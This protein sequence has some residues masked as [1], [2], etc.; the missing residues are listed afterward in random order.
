[1]ARHKLA[2]LTGLVYLLVVLAG[3]FTLLYV[4]GK[5]YVRGDASATAANILAFQPLFQ[6]KIIVSIVSEF[7]FVATV[8][9]LYQLLKDVSRPLATAMVVIILLDAPLAFL[10]VANEAATLAFLRGGEFL[11]V[12]DKP[13]R[14]ALATLL[15]SVDRASVPIS[16]VFWGLWLLPL[17]VLV[18][19]S[20]FLPR[21]LGAWLF[22]NGLA[23]LALS[24]T[25]LV[26]P[27]H[28]KALMSA[29]TPVLLGEMA[30]MLWLLIKGAKEPSGH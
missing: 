1:M 11:A 4:P 3:P 16:E 25:G 22:V 2:R 12:F 8:L 20:R 18:Y 9:M 5:L 19:R 21:F 14:D 27:Q 7:A 24:V 6:A 10:G 13:Q 30:L 26:W 17:G 29:L 23:Y 15:M 28:A